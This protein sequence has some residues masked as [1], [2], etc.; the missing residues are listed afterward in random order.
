MCI[1]A[2]ILASKPG[3]SGTQIYK[4]CASPSL[5]PA[6]IPA[7]FSV[8]LGYQSAIASAQCCN[9]DNCNS[10]TLPS[11][12]TQATNNLECIACDPTTSQCTTPIKC[13]GD[14][15]NCFTATLTSGTTSTPVLGC[16]T[17]NTCVAA[18]KL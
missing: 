2:A 14:E 13:S 1:T 10:Q 17:P 8:N 9:T 3:A 7:T 5:C 6:A 16:A 11:P 15:H 18:A 4:A 12:T